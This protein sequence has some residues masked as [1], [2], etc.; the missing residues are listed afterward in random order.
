MEPRREEL[1]E[2]F[3]KPFEKHVLTE[4]G[5]QSWMVR[6]PD[7]WHFGFI[8]TFTPNPVT[9]GG[10]HLIGDLYTLTLVHPSFKSPEEAAEWVDGAGFHYFMEKAPGVNQEFSG[11]ATLKQ[12]IEWAEDG[13]DDYGYRIAA[14][15]LLH[16]IVEGIAPS[17]ESVRSAIQSDHAYIKDLVEQ[18]RGQDLSRY[19]LEK[20]FEAYGYGHIDDWYGEFGYSRQRQIQYVAFQVWSRLFLEKK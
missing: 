2:K 9:C 10:L 18:A 1:I 8:V 11:E 7:D 6:N 14:I 16:E 17:K 5:P 13:E 12:L 20:A 15:R 19:E 3:R 4:V